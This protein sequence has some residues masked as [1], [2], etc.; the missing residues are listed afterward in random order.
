M[1]IDVEF[2]APGARRGAVGIFHFFRL[3]G[4]F[5]GRCGCG[6]HG[7]VVG[8][9]SHGAAVVGKGLDGGV[10]AHGCILVVGLSWGFGVWSLEATAY[11]RGLGTFYLP[12]M[13]YVSYLQKIVL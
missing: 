10:S 8:D 5:G 11:F 6:S 2:S 3:D 13:W 4:S 9:G 7:L 1:T 12:M